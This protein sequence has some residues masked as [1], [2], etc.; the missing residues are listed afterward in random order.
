[1]WN[2]I[3]ESLT[4]IA[5]IGII[6][7]ALFGLDRCTPKKIDDSKTMKPQ[8]EKIIEVRHDTF[9]VLDS[10]I[11][12]RTKYIDTSRVE[13]VHET[14]NAI[15]K[16]IGNENV[17]IA[18]NQLRQCV[19]CQDSLQMMLKKANIDSQVI[20]SL[21][22]IGMKTPDTVKIQPRLIDRLKDFGSGVLVGAGIRSFF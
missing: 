13:V 5:T 17:C 20:D 1:M 19:K 3:T 2:K 9:H 14:L 10:N 16:P 8:V 12:W 4:L 21:A 22:K 7:F 18:E 11:K 6:I 15:V